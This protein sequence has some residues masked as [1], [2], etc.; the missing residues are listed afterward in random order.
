MLFK[1]KDAISLSKKDTEAP[2]CMEWCNK[3][4]AEYKQNKKLWY[5]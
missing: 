1:D 4:S 5:M 2:D 3:I